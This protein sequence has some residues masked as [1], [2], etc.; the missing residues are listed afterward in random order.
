[1]NFFF[2]GAKKTI[3]KEA[4]PITDGLAAFWLVVLDVRG[5]TSIHFGNSDCLWI[6]HGHTSF[7]IALN[8][9]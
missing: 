9:A 1:M 6:M 3:K 8:V 2:Y 7:D 4:S 5:L